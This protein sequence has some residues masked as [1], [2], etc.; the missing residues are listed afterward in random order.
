VDVKSLRKS[1]LNQIWSPEAG[2]LEGS[3]YVVGFI[4]VSVVVE[5][6]ALVSAE[7]LF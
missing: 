4:P 2:K 3:G 5:M 6:L 1:L 7:P